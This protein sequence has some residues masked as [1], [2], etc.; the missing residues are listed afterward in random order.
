MHRTVA[1]HQWPGLLAHA[2][3]P[4]ARAGSFARC[5]A[6]AGAAAASARAAQRC[7]LCL[8]V[9]CP[10]FHG[11][12]GCALGHLAG[13][14]QV[15]SSDP[16]D[17]CTVTAATSRLRG[18]PAA[19]CRSALEYYGPLQFQ[20]APGGCCG[21]GSHA[22]TYDPCVE[23]SIKATGMQYRVASAA[24]SVRTPWHERSTQLQIEA[25]PPV[26]SEE[27]KHRVQQRAATACRG[28]PLST[29]H[30]AQTALA[31]PPGRPPRRP[32]QRRR[33]RGAA[34]PARASRSSPGPPARCVSAS[35]PR[36]PSAQ[37]LT[38]APLQRR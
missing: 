30:C 15:A 17:Y 11:V 23:R 10:S 4:F 24:C 16:E 28:P 14:I 21:L 33:R 34:W 22:R 35:I 5:R 6:A 37:C 32:R 36:S 20:L 12:A 13:H 19:A 25:G 31:G 18:T 7:L 27:R 38:F 29:R 26:A 9:W 8:L 1:C 2:S 3:S